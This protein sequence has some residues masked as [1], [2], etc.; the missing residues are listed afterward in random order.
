M[1]SG[2][3]WRYY[4]LQLSGEERS[5]VGGPFLIIGSSRKRRDRL[6]RTHQVALDLIGHLG[7]ELP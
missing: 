7:Q 6:A 1:Q 4:G 5:T 3:E 2:I